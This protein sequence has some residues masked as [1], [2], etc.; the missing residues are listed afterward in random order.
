MSGR[1][2]G[3][4]PNAGAPAKPPMTKMEFDMVQAMTFANRSKLACAVELTRMRVGRAT[5]PGVREKRAVTVRWIER[6]LLSRFGIIWESAQSKRRRERALARRNQ[7]AVAIRGPVPH[8][9]APDA[10]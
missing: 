3:A 9:E 8:Q 6:Q 2:G 5:T 7:G 10:S 4:R 1:R